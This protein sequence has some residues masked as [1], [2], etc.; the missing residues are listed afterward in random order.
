M[1]IL[2]DPIGMDLLERILPLM[3]ERSEVRAA[4]L[5]IKHAMH[6]AQSRIAS[7]RAQIDDTSDESAQ[8]L[9]L[10]WAI[11]N[12]EK[13]LHSYDREICELL[14]MTLDLR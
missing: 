1:D 9:E 5:K 7:C 12:E 6:Q 10:E 3:S 4:L 14:S 11:I 8:A 13:R 2:S